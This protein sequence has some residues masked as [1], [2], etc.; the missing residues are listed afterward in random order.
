[1]SDGPPAPRRSIMS[2]QSGYAVVELPDK[3]SP[4]E[5]ADVETWLE[6]LLRRYRRPL[7]APPVERTEGT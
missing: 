7:P 5:V 3:M 1:M 2:L 6:I 4:D